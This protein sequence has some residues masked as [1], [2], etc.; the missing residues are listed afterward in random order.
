MSCECQGQNDAGSGRVVTS[1]IILSFWLVGAGGVSG[2]SLR[3][4]GGLIA[5]S[6]GSRDLYF[7]T[8]GQWSHAAGSSG[9]AG[10]NPRPSSCPSAMLSRRVCQGMAQNITKG[11]SA[12]L[13]RSDQGGGPSTGSS[14]SGSLRCSAATH[15]HAARTRSTASSGICRP[16]V[17]PRSTRLSCRT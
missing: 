12:Y 5:T 1:Q 17:P 3:L 15:A 8:R 4:R 13:Q 14:A 10:R 9:S 11:G 6:G 16:W 2:G 7:P